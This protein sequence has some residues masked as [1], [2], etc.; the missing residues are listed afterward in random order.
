MSRALFE[1]NR[2]IAIAV[3]DVGA[4]ARFEDDALRETMLAECDDRYVFGTGGVGVGSCGPATRSVRRFLLRHAASCDAQIAVH[5]ELDPSNGE[6]RES[7]FGVCVQVPGYR[8][9]RLNGSVVYVDN[10]EDTRGTDF[11][12]PEVSDPIGGL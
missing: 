11:P 7:T 1:R 8:L 6:V 9:S 5:G 10:D 4:S 2:V 3:A 12:V